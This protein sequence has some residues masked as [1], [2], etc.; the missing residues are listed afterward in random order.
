MCKYIKML[1]TEIQRHRITSYNVCYTK[2]LRATS[3]NAAGIV[4]EGPHYDA[5]VATT[6]DVQS[7]L[8]L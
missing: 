4:T 7:A 6:T 1:V 2:L 8:G 5:T 3:T